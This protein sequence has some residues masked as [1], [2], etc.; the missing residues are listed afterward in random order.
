MMTLP[1][2][3]GAARTLDL[4]QGLDVKTVD[5]QVA[6]CARQHDT[7]NRR[8]AFWL[9]EIKDR[10][11]YK[12]FG[13]CDVAHYAEARHGI[14]RRRTRELVYIGRKLLAL[15]EIDRAFCDQR[16]GWSKV[17]LLAQ[18]AVPAH[19]QAWLER[20]LELT[21]RDLKR[22]VARSKEGQAPRKPGDRRGLTEARF[23]LRA[24]FNAMQQTKWDTAKRAYAEETGE[25]VNDAELAEKLSDLFL[26]SRPNGTLPGR[27]PA[28][29]SLYQ[30]VLQEDGEDL[31]VD[32]EELGPVPVENHECIRCD[33]NGGTDK[34]TPSKLRD[35]VLARDKRRCCCCG[36]RLSLQVHHMEYRSKGGRTIKKN[37]ISLCTRCHGL[38][39]DDLLVIVGGDATDVIFQN[40]FGDDLHAPGGYVDP[41]ALVKLRPPKR[42]PLTE[43]PAQPSRAAE[44]PVTLKDVPDTIDADW[45]NRHADLIGMKAGKE[46]EFRPGQ[47]LAEDEVDTGTQAPPEPVP[48]ADAFAGVVGQDARLKRFET[49]LE[50]RRARDESF[51]HTLL[52]G[53][54]G[55]GKTTLAKGIAKAAGTRLIRVCGSLLSDVHTLVR[56]LASLGKH[57]VLF[58]DEIHA[59]P[60]S[61]LEALHEAM[62]EGQISLTL[63]T[64]ARSREV[65]FALPAFTVLAATTDEGGLTTPLRNRFGLRESLDFYPPE[66]LAA[67]ITVQGR[68]QGL[69]LVPEAALHLATFSRGTPREALRLL[70]RVVDDAASRGARTADR[71][72]VEQV[73]EQL[74]FDA[75]GLD[76]LEQRYLEVL[77][78]HAD[79]MSLGLLARTLGVPR[80][81]LTRFAEPH[82]FRKGLVHMTTH[83]RAAGSG[84]KPLRPWSDA[85][86]LVHAGGN[87][88]LRL[89]GRS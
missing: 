88:G 48:F 79:P 29:E 65:C 69:E 87:L 42:A 30:L 5:T 76:A 20:A 25:R 8:L 23:P 71:P 4:V 13:Y 72:A 28:P 58:L 73:L 86:R 44:P 9:T 47:P 15:P 61:V 85:D 6:L 70:E 11:I 14:P 56:S 52:V 89:V 38:I 46:L 40:A 43:E 80:S 37:L 41:K 54:P 2:A 82:L 62:E 63:R 26:G 34:P 33:A 17:R 53:P 3:S 39:H 57:D 75:Q 51:P 35:K 60:G 68:K 7:S 77:R 24:S 18:V 83:G 84:P 19:E 21:V 36:N 10:Q 81:T 22:E 64:G 55:T 66:D 27:T 59:A 50:G 78:E 67:L 74:G 12:L 45:W 49:S 16:I 31:L 32:T 1:T